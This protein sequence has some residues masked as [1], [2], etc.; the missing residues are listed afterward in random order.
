[1]EEKVITLQQKITD[2]KTKNQLIYIILVFLLMNS[3]NSYSN[4][5]FQKTKG[6]STTITKNNIISLNPLQLYVGEL[7]INFENQRN[8]KRYNIYGLGISYMT[9]EFNNKLENLTTFPLEICSDYYYGFNL[10]YGEKFLLKKHAYGSILAFFK[11]EKDKNYRVSDCVYDR[12]YGVCGG[13]ETTSLSPYRDKY[14]LG[15]KFLLG[16]QN[17]PKHKFIYNIYLGLGFRFIY[18]LI[19]ATKQK[20][21]FWQKKSINMVNF[22]RFSGNL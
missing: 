1:M 21:L 5:V 12:Y 22:E 9:N 19:S 6:D 13:D 14:V 4:T 16:F 17:Y 11:Y 7:R 20:A 10:S 8:E 15:N 2:M 3:F 18:Y